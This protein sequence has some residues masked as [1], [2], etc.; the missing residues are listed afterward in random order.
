MGAGEKRAY[1]VDFCPEEGYE[2]VALL[3]CDIGV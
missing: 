1:G 3:F 2:A